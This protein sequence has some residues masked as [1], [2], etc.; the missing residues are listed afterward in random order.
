MFESFLDFNEIRKKPYMML[1]WSMLISS[2]AILIAM[3]ISYRVAISGVVFNLSGVF[4][5]LFTI[6]PAV[7][8]I[9]LV[10]KTEE[11]LEERDILKYHRKSFW[12]RHE[13]YLQWMGLFFIGIT[14]AFSLWS[15]A[16]PQD[17]FQVQNSKID[18]IQ[19]S[20]TEGN[21]IRGDFGSFAM[22]VQN[23][24]QVMLF[25]FVFSLIFG[26]GAI[27]IITWNASILGIA[28]TRGSSFVHEIP[29][30]GM[31]YLPHG[32]PEIL[33]YLCAGLAG[34]ILSAAIIR[35][36]DNR[37]L[38]LIAFDAA[39]ILFLAIVLIVIAGGIEVYL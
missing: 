17:F 32:I 21:Y 33:A 3:Q 2:I 10:I 30:V 16:L 31:R 5:V 25:A 12:Q 35:K 28:I 6:I 29:L 23:N 7:Y 22:V 38:K 34:G 20:F 36:H 24:L 37:I 15:F 11:S 8:F 9:T 26:A 19:G 27:F 39:K 1:V 18:Q 13:L 14:L 4:S